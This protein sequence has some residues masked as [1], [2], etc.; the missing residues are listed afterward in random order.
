MFNF[1]EIIKRLYAEPNKKVVLEIQ[2][3][4]I[5]YILQTI[6][7][8][9]SAY[10]RIDLRGMEKIAISFEVTDIKYPSLDVA[11]K[12]AL[13]SV[14]VIIY[15]IKHIP[16]ARQTQFGEVLIDWIQTKEPI[17]EQLILLRV[18]ETT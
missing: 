3:N 17:D 7:N 2:G 9:S 13:M 1:E 15:A 8:Y 11:S 14:D 6:S 16:R 18:D 12:I 10:K 5:D 4:G